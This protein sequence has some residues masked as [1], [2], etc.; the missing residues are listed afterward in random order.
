[1]RAA[2]HNAPKPY[3][4][5]YQD[6][7]IEAAQIMGLKQGPMNVLTYLVKH[8][9]GSNGQAYPSKD[10]LSGLG[11][12]CKRTVQTHLGK[13]RETGLIEPLAYETGG[14]GRATVYK[15]GLPMWSSP[16]APKNG[17]K[18]AWLREQRQTYGANSATYGAI[19]A[20]YGANT[21]H[22]Q[23]KNKDKQ[24]KGIEA[25]ASRGPVPDNAK[26]IG[27]DASERRNGVS[28]TELLSQRGMTYGNARAQ[29]D[30]WAEDA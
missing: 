18:I 12:M 2:A 25:T 29:W 13:L 4:F 3:G 20:T 28:F 7:V 6:A 22:Q 17:A 1:M 19:F 10:T 9:N 16:R 27:T 15:F 24:G 30:A 14:H 5:K 11:G 23:E 26:G 8:C 21:A